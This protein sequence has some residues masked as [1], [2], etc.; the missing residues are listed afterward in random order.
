MQ[1]VENLIFAITQDTR[2]EG[3]FGNPE[4]LL[5]DLRIEIAKL[6][7]VWNNPD[8]ERIH[9]PMPGEIQW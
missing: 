3:G 9:Q 8:L 7:R 6:Q 2:H 1:L 4:K 5:G